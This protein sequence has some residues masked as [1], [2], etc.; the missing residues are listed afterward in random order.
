MKKLLPL[1]LLAASCGSQTNDT[2]RVNIPKP[3]EIDA[4]A[5]SQMPGKTNAPGQVGRE[6]PA[7][8]GPMR[9]Q[10]AQPQQVRPTFE[11]GIRLTI[12]ACRR[13]LDAPD[14]LIYQHVVKYWN[15]EQQARAQQEAAQRQAQ[16][17]NQKP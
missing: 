16:A 15:D 1:I 10:S 6:T 9:L 14:P 7:S 17:Q 8:A 4:K 2:N 3:P 12:L 5:A 11:D 13:N